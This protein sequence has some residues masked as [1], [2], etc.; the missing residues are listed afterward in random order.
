MR[1]ILKKFVCRDEA[2]ALKKMELIAKEGAERLHFLL[3]FDR[4]LTPSDNG[5]SQDASTWGLLES[6]LREDMVAEIKGLYKKYRPLEIQNK[7]TAQ[8]A[9]EWWEA[10][11]EVHKKNGTKW[12]DIALDVDKK[13]AIRPYVKEFFSACGEKNIPAVIISAG[14]RDVIELW[15]QKFDIRPAGLLST[16]L[17][18]DE[19]GRMNGWEKDSLV[20]TLNKNEM[21]HRE[22]KE[23]MECRPNIILMGDTMDDASMAAGEEN[24]LRIIIDDPRK[25]E[26]RDGS[27]YDSAFQKFDLIIKGKSW[28]PL[29]GIFDLL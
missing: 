1:D 9:V 20:H 13:M 21:A 4:T 6:H 27:F 26:T 25:D 2:K 8:D 17:F 23:I 28:E 7:M 24:V 22:L 19:K 11:L 29:M 5:S 15:F 16:N 18:F 14:I 12:S 10:S 3:D